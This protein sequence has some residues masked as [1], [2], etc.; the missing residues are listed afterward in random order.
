MIFLRELLNFE[1]AHNCQEIEAQFIRA[2]EIIITEYELARSHHVWCIQA[3]ELYLDRPGV[4]KD[5]TVHASKFKEAR[6]QL[7]CCTWYVHRGGKLPPKRLGIDITAGS[8]SKEIYAGLLI[9]ALGEFD[10]SG[11]AVKTILRGDAKSDKD[12]R[13]NDDERN[14]LKQ[15]HGKPV[16]SEVLSLRRRKDK[17][18]VSSLWIG[19]RKLGK[20]VEAKDRDR[21][22]RVSVGKFNWLQASCRELQLN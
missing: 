10:G 9:A 13:Y 6:E 15:I 4:C 1:R 21:P 16:D 11:R 5:D 14:L 3:L 22:L 8:D 19:P 7:K 17:R 12:W 2:A 20:K 18:D